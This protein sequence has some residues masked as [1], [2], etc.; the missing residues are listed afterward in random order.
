M[1]VRLPSCPLL[2]AEVRQL[3]STPLLVGLL[4]RDISDFLTFTWKR[5]MLTSLVMTLPALPTG[6]INPDN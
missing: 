3:A 1:A 4:D 6:S 5:A 2:I